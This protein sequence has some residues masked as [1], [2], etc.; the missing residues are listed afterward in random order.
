MFLK[1]VV[2]MNE[3]SFIVVTITSLNLK[4]LTI[5]YYL[6]RNAQVKTTHACCSQRFSAFLLFCFSNIQILYI[7]IY[8]YISTHTRVSSF[9]G[10]ISAAWVSEQR[11]ADVTRVLKDIYIYTYIYIY[12]YIYMYI[13]TYIYIYVCI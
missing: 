3:K 8:I 5:S 11:T 7:Y 9:P 12:I 4:S 2:P 10:L 13:Y 6:C 1:F